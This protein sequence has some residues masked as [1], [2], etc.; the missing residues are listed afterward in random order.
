MQRI[1]ESQTYTNEEGWSPSEW[2]DAA[3]PTVPLAKDP[4]IGM[5]RQGNG[6][7]VFSY[8]PRTK[9]T[10]SILRQQWTWV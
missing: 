3:H 10:A 8:D 5:K 6:S 7:A 9:A 1:L 4:T 2:A